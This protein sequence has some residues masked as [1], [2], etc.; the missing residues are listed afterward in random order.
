VLRA[1]SRSALLVVESRPALSKLGGPVPALLAS[2]PCRSGPVRHPERPSEVRR[3]S[4]ADDIR[5][6]ADGQQALE[7]QV[8]GVPKACSRQLGPEGRRAR[9]REGAF[10]LA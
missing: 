8:G 1:P 10:Q 9:V 5:D 6:L 3:L 7:E 2:P 4:V